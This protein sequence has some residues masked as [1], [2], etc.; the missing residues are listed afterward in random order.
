MDLYPIKMVLKIIKYMYGVLTLQIE[1][2]MNLKILIK[3]TQK[4][5]VKQ[6][7]SGKINKRQCFKKAILWYRH[8][9]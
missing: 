7:L 1:I 4:V 5:M 3:I 2:F 9:V 8:H 6:S